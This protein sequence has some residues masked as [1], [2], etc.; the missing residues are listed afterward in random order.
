MATRVELG[1]YICVTKICTVLTCTFFIFPFFLLIFF[2][3]MQSSNLLS[4][5]VFISQELISLAFE[6]KQPLFN[7]DVKHVYSTSEGHLVWAWSHAY[8]VH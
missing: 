2:F 3:T 6:L 4:V 1:L 7:I 8:T 5:N